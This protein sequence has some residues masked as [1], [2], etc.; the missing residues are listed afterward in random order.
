MCAGKLSHFVSS[1]VDEHHVFA[2]TP[3]TFP[4]INSF[5]LLLNPTLETLKLYYI[6]CCQFILGSLSGRYRILG[7]PIQQFNLIEPD[8]PKPSTIITGRINYA[9]RGILSAVL[10]SIH[11]VKLNQQKT[12]F[13][14]H[15]PCN[16]I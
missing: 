8:A 6:M 10:Y 15:T 4:V 16:D 1:T 5:R 3:H 12:M 14:G 11:G 13:G 9:L 7:V 2:L